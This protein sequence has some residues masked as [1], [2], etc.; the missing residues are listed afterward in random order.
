MHSNNDDIARGLTRRELLRRLGSGVGVAAA[1]APAADR[2]LPTLLAQGSPASKSAASEIH[3][4]PEY[5]GRGRLGLWTESGIVDT[6][7][8][9]G[10]PVLWRTPLKAGYA[11]PSVAD[12]RVFITDFIETVKL[13][14]TERVLALDEATGSILWKKEWE[15]S[16]GALSYN[17]AI[18]PRA[19]PTV[20][21]ERVYVL[22]AAGML[23]CLNVKSGDVIWQ[24]DYVKDYKADLPTWGMTGAPLVDGHQLI[25]LVG[26]ADNAKVVSFDKLTGK[27]LWRALASNSEPGYSQPTIIY[28][29]GARQLIIW[30]PSAISSLDPETGKLHWEFPAVV[31]AGMAIATPVLSGRRLFVSSFYNGSMMIELD[32]KT[33]TAKV[34]WKGNSDSEII[35]EGL[36]STIN[37]AIIDGDYIYGICSY[38]QFRCLNATT[39]ERIWE[40]QAVTKERARWASGLM[41]KNGDRVFINTDR[42]DLVMARVN[43]QGYTELSRTA[44]IKPTSPPGNRRELISVNWSHPAYANRHIYVRNDEEMVAYSL[45]KDGK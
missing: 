5:R 40:T 8:D 30:H 19:T 14:G 1:A 4:W 27:E 7:P 31:G 10:L 29:G 43:P 22:G 11:G 12:H 41:V 6:F 13:R 42:G 15:A 39:G 33:P 23:W 34:L 45:A 9:S 25:C 24:K 26:G 16:Y 36:H 37:T 35:T 20:D 18:G 38:G 28:A 3:D 32:D 21:G 17:W 2:W 44:L